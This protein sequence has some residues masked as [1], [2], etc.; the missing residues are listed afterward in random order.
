MIEILKL[1]NNI[2]LSSRDDLEA[3]LPQIYRKNCECKEL[4]ESKFDPELETRA[5]VKYK[6]QIILEFFPYKGFGRLRYSVMR[7]ALKNFKDISVN[8]KLI[9]EL[10]MIHVEKGVEFTNAYGDIDDRFYDNI[11]GMYAKV[12]RYIAEH[13]LHTIFRQRCR[14]VV[15]QTE[16]MGW[17]FHDG[18][19]DLYHK[20]YTE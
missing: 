5:F 11:A 3:L 17:G 16:G 18:L 1:K 4:I 10:M 9:A 12:L 7:K 8:H 6:K 19:G 15:E 14:E 20:Y 13:N 2:A